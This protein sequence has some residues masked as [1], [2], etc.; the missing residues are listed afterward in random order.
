[1]VIKQILSFALNEKG[2]FVREILLDELAKGLDALRVA[3]LDSVTSAMTANLPFRPNSISSMTDED[4]TNLRILRRLILLLSGL[5]QTE[6]SAMEVKGVGSYDI[7]KSSPNEAAFLPYGL[8]SGQEMLPLLS[9]IAELPPDSQQ[10]LLRLPADLAGKLVSRVA[11]RTIRW[12][13]L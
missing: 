11:A 13:F 10:Q 1:M 6:T 9:A 5:Q 7:Q 3:T 2:A 4:I 8:V 12:A